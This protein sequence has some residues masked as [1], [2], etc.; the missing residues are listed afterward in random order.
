MTQMV[1]NPPAMQKTQV[2]SLGWEDPL[3]KGMATHSSILAWT[4]PWTEE[5]EIYSLPESNTTEPLTLHNKFFNV[6][7]ETI[8]ELPTILVSA[9]SDSYLKL[10]NHRSNFSL[11]LLLNPLSHDNSYFLR[12]ILNIFS[13]KLLWTH[14]G[15]IQFSSSIL[16]T[17]A[18]LVAQ[19][20]KNPL[21]MQETQVRSLGWED[22]LE[23]G[24]PTHSS[25]LAW[26]I[27]W[28]EEP[29]RLQS[30]VSQKFRHN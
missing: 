12:L 10:Q 22:P 9:F 1:K 17:G 27:P 11:P 16:S 5:L 7:P 29:G 21:A 8:P 24:M 14:S 19:M 13:R 4:N 28:T 15:C 18:S 25:I 6:T 30:M 20:V 26:R 23:K 3:A 2:R